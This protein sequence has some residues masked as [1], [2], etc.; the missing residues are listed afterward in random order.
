MFAGFK[1]IYKH[2]FR[3]SYKLLKELAQ[4]IMRVSFYI[5]PI[6]IRKLGG[7]QQRVLV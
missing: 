3:D 7:G 6:E 5:L 2:L 1:T 4:L